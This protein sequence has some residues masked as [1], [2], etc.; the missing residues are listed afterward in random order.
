M[1]AMCKNETLSRGGKR[2]TH[3]H[4]VSIGIVDVLT[5]WLTSPHTGTLDFKC[6]C[7]SRCV[8]LL[9]GVP[10]GLVGQIM[11][12]QGDKGMYTNL[13]ILLLSHSSIL[14]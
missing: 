1:S 7:Q 2:L 6:S 3:L 9:Y 11:K 10:G 12:W 14:L 13:H 5:V 4:M 8:S